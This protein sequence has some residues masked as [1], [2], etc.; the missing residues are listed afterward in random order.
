MFFLSEL[1]AWVIY[2]LTIESMI[3]YPDIAIPFD[4]LTT[5]SF[6]PNFECSFCVREILSGLNF[7]TDYLYVRLRYI[8]VNGFKPIDMA[9]GNLSLCQ[10]RIRHVGPFHV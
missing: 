7:C 5:F 2:L 6:V 1:L 4:F 8:V 10:K 9:Y 3:I